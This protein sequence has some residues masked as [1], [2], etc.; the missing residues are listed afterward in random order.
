MRSAKPEQLAHGLPFALGEARERLVEQQHL[1]LLRQRHGELQPSPLAVGGFGDDAVGTIAETDLGQRV[2]RLRIEMTMA[3]QQRPGI[4]AQFVEAEQRQHDVVGERLAGKQCQDLIGP[5]ETALHTV[6]CAHAEEFT[7]EQ[8]DRAAVGGEIAG[9]QVEQSGL[10][11][12]VRSDD[13]PPLAGH[14]GERNILGRRQAAEALVEA[15]DFKGCFGHVALSD[16]AL[17][18]AGLLRVAILRHSVRQ[19]GTRP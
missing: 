11:G 5:G 2:A 17:V 8:P 18:G 14:D 16:A 1:G 9:D 12:A 10:A 19:P 13:Q 7:A 6:G 15:Y 3:G 4:P